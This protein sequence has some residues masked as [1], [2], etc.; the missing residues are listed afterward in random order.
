MIV[1]CWCLIG[2]FGLIVFGHT[3]AWLLYVPVAAR[4]LGE[5]PWLPAQWREPL[6][7]GTDVTFSTEDGARLEGIYLR[8]TAAKRKGVIAFCHELNGDRW[9]SVPYT[10]DLRRQGFDIFTFDFRNHGTSDCIAG[11]EPMPW[12][13]RYDLA[14]V[15]AAIDYLCTRPDAE[16]DGIGLMGVSK[17][18][19][20]ALCT[21]AFDCR[22]RTL[23]VDGACPTERM[24]VHYIRRFMKIFVRYPWLI[25]LLPD[26]SLQ[27]TSAWARV[28]LGRRRNC[29]FVNVDQAARR[30][31]Q[32]VMMIH[33]RCD[34]HIPLAVVQALRNSMS[35]R[36]RLWVIPQAKHNGSITVARSAYHRRIARF[37]DRHLASEPHAKDRHRPKSRRRVVVA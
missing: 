28:V 21:A 17:G 8:T 13:T 1:L 29:R 19:T 15:R 25:S 33:G 3:L 27:T 35:S 6:R 22:V 20:V 26:I 31:H 4:V 24:Q 11:Y 37:F 10:E 16:P 2:L 9:S 5:T 30:V 18:G 12:V 36:T 14:D 32:P 34:T 23:V 7:D